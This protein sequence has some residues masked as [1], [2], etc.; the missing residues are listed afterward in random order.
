MSLIVD[1][2]EV[3]GTKSVQM[4]IEGYCTYEK[5]KLLLYKDGEKIYSEECI[6]SEKQKEMHISLPL[7][8]VRGDYKI[9]F[10]VDSKKVYTREVKISLMGQLYKRL[11][12]IY[13]NRNK[14]EYAENT[15]SIKKFIVEKCI[16]YGTLRPQLCIKGAFSSKGYKLL[17][18]KNKKKIFEGSANERRED[19]NHLFETPKNLKNGFEYLI[20]L[21][22]FSSIIYFD[23]EREGEVVYRRRLDNNFLLKLFRKV[24][25][26]IKL[27]GRAIRFLW[28]KHHFL[29]PPK[30]IPYYYR[31][32]KEKIEFSD[33]NMQFLDPF[34]PKEYGQW[35]MLHEQIDEVIPQ[36][37]NPLISIVTPVYNV[38]EEYLVACLESVLAQSY[39]NWEFCLADDCSPDENVRKVLKRYEKKDPR[40]KVVY[41]KKNGRISEATNS[42]LEI[43]KGEYIGLLD[44]DDTLTVDA[45]YEV[46]KALNKNKK[47]DLIYSD[48]DKINVKGERCDP[49][50]KTDWSPDTF[51]SNNYLCHFTVM[52]K[53]ILDKIGGE[54]SAYDGAQDFDLFLRFTEKAKVIHHIP[55]V[56]YHWRIIPG[57]TSET[58]GAK[59]YALEAGKNALEDALK[60]RK[61]KGT[62]LSNGDGTYIIQYVIN[63]PKVS[64]IIPTRDYADT[65]DVCLKSIYE[66]STYPNFEI[67]VVDNGST[68]KATFKLFDAYKKEH[69]NFK[70][71]RLDCEFNYS[72]INNAAVKKATG[73]YIL[74]L[75]NDTSVIT[76]DW[77]EQMVMYASQKHAGTVGAKLYYPD[78]TIQHGG[79]VMGI[80]GVA[81]HAYLGY[82]R[83]FGG[84]FGKLKAPCNYGGNTAACLMVSK[85]KYEQVNGLDEKLKV[86][87]ND[88][89]FNLKMTDAGYY[90]I[91]LPQVELY[92]YESKSRGLDVSKEKYEQT[93][94]ESKYIRD[95]WEDK[96]RI[97]P[98]YNPNYS[99]NE[100]YKLEK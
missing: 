52:R 94:K 21:S 43:A 50:F 4:Q 77:I 49:Y 8:S 39:E 55:K 45:L 41:R 42:A 81:G 46:V 80:R 100:I 3:Y 40:I 26:Y 9:V 72:H 11:R 48:E 44:N 82:G 10:K 14:L 65:L 89:D 33:S 19:V 25:K 37:Y 93:Q 24:W 27:V 87:Y 97:D 92:H 99:L 12:E 13:R 18:Y 6:F 5:V 84:Y 31:K 68:E 66:K 15:G 57:S 36:K 69:D 62:V 91:F 7:P 1:K 29:V 28:K 53:S 74:L 96:L 78:N 34:N 85:K 35:L 95:K 17:V 20:P 71:L 70:V 16:I 30:M 79:M 56:L 2:I 63:N 61:I 83:D 90:N 58:I 38:P 73:D 59:S 51:M 64:I 67:I 98:F 86:N 22:F 54:R 60:R 76:P 47:I 32:L 75:N 23:I 88:V